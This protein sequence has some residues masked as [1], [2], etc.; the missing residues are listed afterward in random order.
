MYLFIYLILALAVLHTL[1]LYEPVFVL[2]AFIRRA[3]SH[4][5]N[6]QVMNQSRLIHDQ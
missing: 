2:L 1:G 3:E 5:G 6:W 4:Q